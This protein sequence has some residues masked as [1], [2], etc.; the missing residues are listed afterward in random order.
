MVALGDDPA[1]VQHDDLI[2]QRD[3]RESV[4]D[5]ERGAARHCLGERQLDALLGGGVHR[6]GGVVEHQHARVGQ[7]R[8]RDRDALALPTGDRQAA[9]ADLGL[10]ALGQAADEVVRLRAPGGRFDLLD[11]GVGA[12]V[13]DVLGDRGGEQEG[14]VADDR[15]RGAQRAQAHLADVGSVQQHAARGRVVQ[16]RDQR[17]EAGLARARGSHQRDGL[18][19][20]HVEVDVVQHRARLL[21]RGRVGRSRTPIPASS[22]WGSS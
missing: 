8:A 4:G 12:G 11:R 19:R 21:W 5:H 3:R 10:V 7:Q 17:H 14:V 9:L 16:P 1:A 22:S 2:R 20:G 6:G 18:P 13:G 15:H